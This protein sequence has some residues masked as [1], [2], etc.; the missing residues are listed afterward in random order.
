MF[1][2]KAQHLN[3]DLLKRE[4]AGTFNTSQL[5]WLNVISGYN[6]IK[7]GTL[8]ILHAYVTQ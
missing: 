5:G 4:N 8:V 1:D 6:R 3:F 2:I 7:T